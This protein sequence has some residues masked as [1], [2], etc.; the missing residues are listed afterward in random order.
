MHTR[1]I[2]DRLQENGV[3]IQRV[4][5]GGGIPRTNTT[6]N[7]IYAN[8]LGK[9]VLVPAS[10]VTGLGAA[11][12]AFLA[13]GTFHSLEEAQHAVGPCYKT[14]S[15]EAE[16][17]ATYEQLFP[18][19]RKLY[20]AFGQPIAAPVAAGDVLPELRR[21]ASEVRTRTAQETV[22]AAS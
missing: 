16:Q 7:Q 1:V 21:I 12:F 18:L 11:I 6:L 17:T 8:V 2:F 20:F 19:F 5:N 14:Y 10:N 9:P 4:I 13:A 15:P 3:A 22:T